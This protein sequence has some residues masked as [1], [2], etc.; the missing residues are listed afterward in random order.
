M[1]KTVFFDLD[2]TLL[3]FRRAEA[4]SLRQTLPVFGIDPAPAV[5][6]RYHEINIAQWQLLEQGKLTR[7]QVLLRRYELLFAELGAEHTD[8][9]AVCARYEENLAFGHWFIPGAEELLETLAPRYDLYLA[10]NGTAAVQR[11]RLR[12]TGLTRYFKG[13]FISEEMGADKP[14]AEYFRRCFA[15]IPDFD[16]A[17]AVMV[18]DSLTSDIRGGQNAGIR[19]CWFNPAGKPPRPDIRPDCIIQTL[20]ELP[21]LLETL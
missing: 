13:I 2:D 14:S 3:D 15:A 1:V 16:P 17:S 9:A 19:T 21:A 5:L 6:D 4:E 20:E 7:E 18:G 11:S 10:T 8:P 12:L